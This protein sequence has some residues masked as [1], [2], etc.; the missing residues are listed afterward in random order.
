[1]A[2]R[3]I[4]RLDVKPPNLVKGVHLEGVRKLGRPEDFAL[5]YYRGGIDELIY[6]DVVASLYGRNNIAA[7]VQQTAQEIFVPLTVGGGIRHVDDIQMLLRGGADKVSINTMAVKNP[8]LIPEAA[9]LFGTQCLTVAIEAI[10][11][12]PNRWEPLVESGRQH[13]HLDAEQW[14]T[15]VVSLGAGELLVTSIAAEGARKG[16]DFGLGDRLLRQVKVPVLLHGGAGSPDDVVE[17]AKRGY[18]GAVLASLLHYNVAT[19]EQIKNRL[20]QAHIPV[21]T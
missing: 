14:A 5:K 16:F 18:S 10:A 19:V 8:Q 21:R 3:I 11:S 17:V 13:T 2:F 7:L 9:R 1:M 12:G 20:I 15:D 6:Q 4:A